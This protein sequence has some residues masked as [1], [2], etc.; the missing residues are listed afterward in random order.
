MVGESEATKAGICTKS[1]SGFVIAFFKSVINSE[2][3]PESQ[4][5]IR[6]AA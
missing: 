2:R 3:L 1:P 6:E 4:D 5:L